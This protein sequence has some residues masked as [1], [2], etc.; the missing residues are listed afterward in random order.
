MMTFQRPVGKGGGGGGGGGGKRGRG[1]KVRE[2]GIGGRFE[3]KWILGCVILTFSVDE[4]ACGV[5]L[6]LADINRV[7]IGFH[8][9]L[10]NITLPECILEE[11]REEEEGGE[12]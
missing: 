9:Q 7:S 8:D 10:N 3:V 12:R 5:Y 4:V 2:G 1:G 11:E 6:T